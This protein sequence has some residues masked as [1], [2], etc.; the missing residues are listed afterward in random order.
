MSYA[1]LKSKLPQFDSDD[2]REA[3]SAQIVLSHKITSQSIKKSKKNQSRLPRTA[4]LRTLSELTTEMTKAGLDPSRIQERAEM[5]AKLQGAERKRK[6][7]EDGD[8]DV[9]MGDEEG[10]DGEGWM[11]VDDAEVVPT[12]RAKGNSG[13][14]VAVNPK[15]PRTNRQLDGMRDKGVRIHLQFSP[16]MILIFNT[17]HVAIYQVRQVA[18]SRATTSQ[19]AGKGW[20]ERS[21]N[22]SQNGGCLHSAFWHRLT[23][24]LC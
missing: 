21:C 3:T 5:L 16:K 15:V 4:G 13:G 22:Q 23:F 8:G 20:R 14:V 12:K 17:C 7:D 19:Y 10:A 9:D 11:D 24:I 18:Q 1:S 6:R 2:E